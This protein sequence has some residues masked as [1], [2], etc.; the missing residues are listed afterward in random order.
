MVGTLN[1]LIAEGSTVVLPPSSIMSSICPIK[2]YSY[3]GK[4]ELAKLKTD[5]N[6]QYFIQQCK[7]FN[8]IFVSNTI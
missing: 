1:P 4:T 8:I 3:K 6:Q 5:Q 7:N 2:I